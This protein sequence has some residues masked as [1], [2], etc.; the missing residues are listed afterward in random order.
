MGIVILLIVWEAAG[1]FSNVPEY[2]LPLPSSITMA[3]INNSDL[4]ISHS[5]YTLMAA[6][7]GLFTAIIFSA[8]ISLP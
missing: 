7:L 8:L 3:L 2:I 4:L 5:K 6:L 1:R